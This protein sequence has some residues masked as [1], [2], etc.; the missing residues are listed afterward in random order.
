MSA[1]GLRA[2]L[3]LDEL[4]DEQVSEVLEEV[5]AELLPEPIGV[6]AMDFETAEQKFV[7]V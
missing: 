3:G 1:K 7:K 6:G 5:A 2:D 4:T